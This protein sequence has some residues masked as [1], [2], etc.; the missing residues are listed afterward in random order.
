[1]RTLLL[2]L[3][4]A[5]LHAADVTVTGAFARATAPSATTGAVFATIGGAADE[6]TGATTAAADRVELH[7]VVTLDNGAK[8]MT[9]VERLAVPVQLK[10]GSY[11]LMLMGLKA[12]LVEAS[13][14]TLRLTFAKAGIVEVAVPVGGIAASEAPAAAA[15]CGAAADCCA[16]E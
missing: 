13:S 9:P 2:I 7:S 5:A 10:P 12:P 3:A 11:H 1:M 6:L 16:P 14:I 8:R 4:I 15:G